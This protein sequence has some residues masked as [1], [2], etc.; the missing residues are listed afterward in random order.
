VFLAPAGLSL[1]LNFGGCAAV[2]EVWSLKNHAVF[3]ILL[4][5]AELGR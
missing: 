4:R 3:G 2:S 5:T 1:I